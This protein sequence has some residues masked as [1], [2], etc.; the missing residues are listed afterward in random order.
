MVAK[1]L[2]LFAQLLAQSGELAQLLEGAWATGGMF[3]VPLSSLSVYVSNA[4]KTVPVVH[5]CS[6]A[7]LTVYAASSVVV[8]V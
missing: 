2:V 1:T 3:C 8:I 6:E 7:C 4:R 5:C